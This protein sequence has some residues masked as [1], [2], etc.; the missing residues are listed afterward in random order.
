MAFR[1]HNTMFKQFLL[2]CASHEDAYVFL[3]SSRMHALCAN[4]D[5]QT[6]VICHGTWQRNFF[7]RGAGQYFLHIS[8]CL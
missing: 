5:L 7:W 2:H 8:L 1:V 4:D 6:G 3:G